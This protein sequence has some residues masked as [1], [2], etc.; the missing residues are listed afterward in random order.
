MEGLDL[1]FYKGRSKYHTKD[2]SIPGMDGGV[3]ALWS[4]MEATRGAGVALMDEGKTHV[5]EGESG[6]A[7]V[8]FEREP[9][10]Q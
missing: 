3:K 4:M 5:E 9:F 10:F 7:P 6:E 2:D 8:Y 1:A